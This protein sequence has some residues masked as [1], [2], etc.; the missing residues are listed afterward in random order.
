M[1]SGGLEGGRTELLVSCHMC[2][3][4]EWCLCLHSYNYTT[5]CIHAI[6]NLHVA[7]FAI[8]LNKHVCVLQTLLVQPIDLCHTHFLH[9]QLAM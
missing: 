4:G 2:T 9:V 3:Q 6:C 1:G 8:V 5:T 7:E